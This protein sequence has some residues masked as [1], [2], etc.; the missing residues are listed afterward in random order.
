MS[1]APLV[2]IV[3]TFTWSQ[4]ETNKLTCSIL[5]SIVGIMYNK[6]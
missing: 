3:E 1:V 5:P 6:L 4:Y 2:F